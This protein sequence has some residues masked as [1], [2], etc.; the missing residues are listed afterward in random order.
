MIQLTRE[1][2]FSLTV[3]GL[4]APRSNSWSGWPPLTVIAPYLM[5]RCTLQGEIDPES[6]YLCNIQV[7]DQAVREKVIGP[8]CERFPGQ[9][10][11]SLLQF[12][13][14]ELADEFPSN[15]QLKQLDLIASPFLSYHIQAN[16]PAMIQL[17]Q[18]YEFSA[19]HRLNNPE[20][21]DEQNLELF[22]KCNNPQG[23]GHNYVVE[24][25]VAGQST[26]DGPIVSITQMDALVKQMVIDRMD[27]KN[28]NVEVDEFDELNPSVENIAKVIWGYLQPHM[29][30]LGDGEVQ[31]VNI[32]V[33][34]T[35]KT[36][37]D[38]RGQ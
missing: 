36:W 27:H 30:A 21:S 1:V 29:D 16:E 15:C 18:Q 3:D 34:E 6:S 8:A 35:P 5:L 19:S 2:R 38:Y 22:G 33:N 24:V 32:R 20:L 11:E 31:L 37:A 12:A 9:S 25:T 23:H 10:Y 14:Q 26:P 4:S 28:L 17:T 7:V 13:W